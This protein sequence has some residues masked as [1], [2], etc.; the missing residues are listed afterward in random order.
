MRYF[1]QNTSKHLS[2]TQ[3]AQTVTKLSR[4]TLNFFVF[5][6]DFQNM[7]WIIAEFSECCA[8]AVQF[9]RSV[10]RM[11]AHIERKCCWNEWAPY[12]I[13]LI[14]PNLNNLKKV[15]ICKCTR[16]RQTYAI[17]IISRNMKYYSII[18]INMKYLLSLS[19]HN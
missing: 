3:S 5:N 15:I 1:S 9:S 8:I 10:R 13:T 2:Y 7:R 17:D 19:E 12:R 11:C 4:A 16:E 14:A 6:D 18:E